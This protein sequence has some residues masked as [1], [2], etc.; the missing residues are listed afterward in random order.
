LSDPELSLETTHRTSTGS[1]ENIAAEIVVWTEDMDAMVVDD[2]ESAAP[3]GL[4]QEEKA[5]YV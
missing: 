3:A 4:A 2:P 1:S 5:M